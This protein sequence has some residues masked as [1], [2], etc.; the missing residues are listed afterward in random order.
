MRYVGPLSFSTPPCGRRERELTVDYP[1][2]PP[3]Q[4]AL[5]LE[6]VYGLRHLLPASFRG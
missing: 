1:T 5:E 3:T 6:H 2:P 4:Q